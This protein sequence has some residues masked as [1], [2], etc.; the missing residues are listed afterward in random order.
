[1]KHNQNRFFQTLIKGWNRKPSRRKLHKA[2]ALGAA[3]FGVNSQVIAEENAAQAAPVTPV[4]AAVIESAPSTTTLPEVLVTGEH[5]NYKPENVSSPKYTAPLRNIPQT[6]NVVPQ[7]VM[8]DQGATTLRDV[9]RNIP[10][11]SMQAGEGGVPAGDNLS[12]RGFNART[13]I[14]VDGVRD[15][16]G[17]SRDAFSVEQVEVTKGPSSTFMGRGST[18][19]S[20]NMVSKRPTQEASYGGT[21]GFGTHQYKRTTLDL[22]RPIAIEKLPGTAVRVNAMWNEGDAPGRNAVENEKFGI[23]P[24]IAFGLGTPT[25]V[26]L[27]YYHLH[28]DGMP[29]YGIPWVTPTQNVLAPY[30][31]TAAPVDYDNFYGVRGRDYEKTDTTIVTGEIKHKV[32]D[33]LSLRYMLRHGRTDRDSVITAPRFASANNLTINRNFQSRDQEDRVLSNVADVTKEFKTGPVG[34]KMVTGVEI[35]RET[36]I[37]YGRTGP[38]STTNLYA[39]N[40]NDNIV[41]PTYRHGGYNE[42]TAKSAGAYL[43]DTVALNEQFDLTGGVRWDNFAVDY[44]SYSSSTLTTSTLSRTDDMLSWRTGLVFKPTSEGSIYAAYGTSF[45]PSAEGLTLGST[46]TSTNNV[47]VKPEENETY[48][49]GTKWDVAHGRLALNA[50]VFRTD[51]TNARTED[52]TVASDVIVLEGEQRVQGYEVGGS[53]RITDAWYLIGGYTYLDSKVRKSKNVSELG[54]EL[55]NTP[56]HSFNVWSSYTLPFKLEVGAGAQYVGHR[57]NSITGARRAPE[58]WVAD[59]MLAYPVNKNFTLR[60]NGYNLADK[61]YIDR[62]GGGHFIPGASRSFVVSTSV[63]F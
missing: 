31:D 10:G 17:Y 52:P 24:S 1:V 5:K 47:N 16:G 25:E 29:D 55:S 30:R 43:F 27:E 40:V 18:G 36:S 11:I 58:Y 41:G 51:K 39:P 7:D 46:A 56:R 9:L 19:G 21:V 54:R 62:L 53:G 23:A 63:K 60:L 14:F 35:V 12:I 45:N 33:T 61:R 59:A 26:L 3:C 48:E 32:D 34:H 38:S 6:I 15:F 2:V 8:E 42:A 13:D 49:I 50:A 4:T 44:V 28:Q 37:N 20:I 22:N 57:F